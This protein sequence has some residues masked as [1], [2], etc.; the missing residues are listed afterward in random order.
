MSVNKELLGKV[1]QSIADHPGEHNQE[2]WI[3]LPGE[4]EEEGE[5]SFTLDDFQ[6]ECG[7]SACVAGWTLLHEGFQFDID[8]QWDEEFQYHHAVSR[9]VR[10]E[11]ELSEREYPRVAAKALGD[12]EYL[13]SRWGEIFHDM[14]RDQVI[15]RLMY[16]YTTGEF[17]HLTLGGD[18][19]VLLGGRPRLEFVNEWYL[20][21]MDQFPAK[22]D[23]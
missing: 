16:A 5:F 14:H 17:A 21:W 19:S 12:P 20:K 1:L 18:S 9:A 10:G 15:A 6:N 3:G 2:S 11:L 13:Y 22:E 4:G 7:T 8:I 23:A